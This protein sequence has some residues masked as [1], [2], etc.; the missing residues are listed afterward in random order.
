MKMDDHRG[1]PQF[2]K[3][4]NS[5]FATPT[6]NLSTSHWVPQPLPSCDLRTSRA[7]GRCNSPAL[8]LKTGAQIGSEKVKVQLIGN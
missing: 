7:R 1:C 6:I 2:R 4:P 8:P 3:P 5:A